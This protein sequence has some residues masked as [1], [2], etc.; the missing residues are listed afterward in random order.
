[1]IGSHGPLIANPDTNKKRC[2]RQP[3][4]VTV[5]RAVGLH[6]WDIQFDHYGKV[7]T[8]V[9]SRAVKLVPEG[10]GI[11]LNEESTTT[12]GSGNTNSLTGISA[13]MFFVHYLKYAFLII[14][15]FVFN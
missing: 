13:F 8:G 7:N 5:L 12:P 2:I 3:I 10:S 11:P 14:L 15:L 1:V 6:L 9:S 4:I